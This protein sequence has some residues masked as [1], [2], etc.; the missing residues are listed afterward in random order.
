MFDRA[1]LKVMEIQNVWLSRTH[2]RYRR[3]VI[4]ENLRW[5]R[6]KLWLCRVRNKHMV[7]FSS[8]GRCVR[9]GR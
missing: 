7:K 9:C 3:D 5:A 8:A 6:D 2:V 4:K 1:I